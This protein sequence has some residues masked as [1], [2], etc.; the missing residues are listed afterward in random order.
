[1]PKRKTWKQ[2]QH[3]F[4]KLPTSTLKKIARTGSPMKK[5]VA[6]TVLRWEK[7]GIELQKKWKA[8]EK[9]SLM[10]KILPF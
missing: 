8:E 3:E 4:E 7:K 6:K 5:D 1:M 2:L 10:D 9:K